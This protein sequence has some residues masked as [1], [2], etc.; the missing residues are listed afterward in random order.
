MDTQSRLRFI[1]LSIVPP[2]FSKKEAEDDL[3][4]LKSLVSTFGGATI[5]KIIQKREK[6]DKH[7]YIGKG[8]VAEVVELIKT[9]KIDVVVTNA[10]VNPNQLFELEKE[11]WASNRNIKVWD[12]VD[13]ILNIFEKHAITSEAK[14]QIEL[15]RMRHMGP[16]IYGMGMVM[17]RQGGGIGTRGIG[18]TN[19]E[20]MKRHWRDA[21][22]R[23]QDELEKLTGERAR[24]MER[25]REIG[26][27]TVSIVGY[28]NAG[29]S[30]LFNYLTGKK[31]LAKNVLF[32]TLDTTVGKMYLPHLKKEI[33]VSDTIGFIQN[34]P[35]KLI[36]A[37]RST[38]MESVHADLLI[39]VI[40]ICD[41]KM[42][43]KIAV[44]ENVLKEI[45][46]SEKKI[47][48]VFNKIDQLNTSDRA[49]LFDVKEILSHFNK[50]NPQLISVVTGEGI[51]EF[52][53]ALEKEID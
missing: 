19:T 37:F 28:T 31:K 4:E 1:L 26:F 46:L 50:Y 11:F 21:V 30:T 29:K 17:S 45:R 14:L 13:L 2:S 25:R 53:V 5:V 41:P 47:I 16:K 34:L 35:P 44:V 52:I 7:S 39:H 49:V 20:L 36:D 33:M 40:D 15:A 38:L 48:Y 42:Y 32:A 22:K 24:Q 6:P 8:K 3:I 43:D 18:E 27:Q 12:R 9:E 23:I 51:S 10:V